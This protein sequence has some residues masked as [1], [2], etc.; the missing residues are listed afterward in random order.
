M[1]QPIYDV[2]IVGGGPAGVSASIY[3]KKSGLSVLLING[4]HLKSDTNFKIENH[5]GFNN[6][7]LYSDLANLGLSQAE[8]FGVTIINEACYEYY[9]E[10][11]LQVCI[12]STKHYSKTLVIATGI[13]Y[14]KLPLSNFDKYVGQG[15]HFCTLCDGFL[16][17]NKKVVL[18]GYGS[19][20]IH[21]YEYLKEICSDITIY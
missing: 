7:I 1:D 12:T 8:K 3:A 19:Y 9:Q 20:L 18:Y 4:S 16:Y 6:G 11:D 14:R 10:K 21:E 5:Y 13:H 2:I 17:R 15:I